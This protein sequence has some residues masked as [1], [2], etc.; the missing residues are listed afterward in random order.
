MSVKD[1]VKLLLCSIFVCLPLVLAAQELVV[2]ES[3]PKQSSSEQPS[4][5]ESVERVKS[6]RPIEEITVV[7]QKSLARLGRLVV[8]KQEEIFAFFNENNSSDKFDIICKR[9]AAT[10][11][12]IKERV[13]EPRFLS[14]FRGQKAREARMGFGLYYNQREL[15]ELSG[16]E[17]EQLQN[18]MTEMMLTHKEYSDALADLA[19]L[20]ENY[21]SQRVEYF[22]KD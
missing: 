16:E 3:L 20:S 18:E 12:Y 4:V 7:G 11:T 6:S 19:D 21:E 17:F 10:G 13:C 2:D 8:D 9:R 1:C 15:V 14:E 22:S 5:D